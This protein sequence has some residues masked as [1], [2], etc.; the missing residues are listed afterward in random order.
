METLII[1][2]KTIQGLNEKIKSYTKEGYRVVGTHWVVETHQQNRYRGSDH[3]DTIIEHEYSVT[4]VKHETTDEDVHPSLK[5]G[6]YYRYRG[7]DVKI[8]D[9]DEMRNEFE[10]KLSNL[11]NPL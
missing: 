8:Y 10:E 9:E 3:I 6:I 1:G 2:S 4:M 7:G 11:I 5:V